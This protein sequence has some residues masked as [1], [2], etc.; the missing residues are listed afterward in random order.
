MRDRCAT[1][2]GEHGEHKGNER[3]K[4]HQRH[5]DMESP[6]HRG[7]GKKVRISL[8]LGVAK[9]EERSD[10]EGEEAGKVCGIFLFNKITTTQNK[11]SSC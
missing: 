5:E 7:R 6:P 4:G 3:N 11:A 8:D 9:E 1:S 10:L 2:D